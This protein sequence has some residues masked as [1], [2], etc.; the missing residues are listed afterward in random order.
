M[1]H[2][3]GKYAELGRR[4]T[5]GDDLAI[6]CICGACWSVKRIR[7]K[8]G[9][10]PRPAR[11]SRKDRA[12]AGRTALCAVG[13]ERRPQCR[14]GL[15]AAKASQIQFLTESHPAVRTVLS[16]R[17]LYTS[18]MIPHLCTSLLGR[19]KSEEPSRFL[20]LRVEDS[21]TMSIPRELRTN[22]HVCT[23]RLVCGRVYPKQHSG[24]Q[25]SRPAMTVGTRP[26]CVMSPNNWTISRAIRR[27]LIS[28]DGRR[29][30]ISRSPIHRRR[31]HNRS[32][33]HRST[34][35][36]PRMRSGLT[37]YSH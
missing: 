35:S 24:H 26:V 14:L 17:A 20:S 12:G 4:L 25:P 11:G 21:S 30:H 8:H 32:A 37:R 7:N 23:H 5:V 6:H 28:N 33:I 19:L 13:V 16:F 31:Y 34:V 22:P 1:S 10:P 36:T 2:H 3:L 18:G 29:R 9:S 15:G 27:C